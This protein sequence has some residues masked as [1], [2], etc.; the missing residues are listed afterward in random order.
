MTAAR[1]AVAFARG[2]LSFLRVSLLGL[3]GLGAGFLLLAF[4]LAAISERHDVCACGDGSHPSG[5]AWGL[6]SPAAH[7]SSL[8][9]G[10]GGGEALP[11]LP[12]R[13]SGR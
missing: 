7:C 1:R 11:L 4:L 3:L 6:S 10:H 13:P 9:A 12:A 8:C 2:A 5:W